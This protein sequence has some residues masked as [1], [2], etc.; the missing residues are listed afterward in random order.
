MKKV[1][2]IIGSKRSS[3]NCEVMA[4][5]ISRQIPEPHQLTLLRLPDFDIRYCTGCYRCLIKGRGCVIGDD[6]SIVLDAIA[7]A[8]ALIL[9]VPTYFLSAHSCLKTFLDRAISFYNMADNL[10]GKPAVGVGIAGIEGKEGSTLLDIERF[11]AT[12]MAKNKQSRIIYGALPGE[13]M[14]SESNL[15]IAAELAHSLF[16]PAKPK[17]GLCCSLCGGETFRFL[18]GDRVRCMLCS[19][20]GTLTARDGQFVLD[21]E[22]GDHVLLA[23]KEEA[24]KHRDWLLGMVGRFKEQKDK[25]REVAAEYTDET[26]WISPNQK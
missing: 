14:L 4:K 3:G 8:D 16:S 12:M 9:A 24:L 10:W 21:I 26:P 25:L 11:F 18:E 6:L 22:A 1:L 23:N 13:T 17:D 2:G 5:E 20:S 19:E 7:D 15:Q